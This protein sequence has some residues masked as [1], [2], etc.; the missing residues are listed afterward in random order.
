[1][2]TLEKPYE[3]IS[4]E[5]HDTMVFYNGAR[6]HVRDL[7]LPKSV[8]RMLTNAL[9]P[10]IQ[11]RPTM[12]IVRNTLMEH[13]AKVVQLGTMT[14]TS[15]SYVTSCAFETFSDYH[16]AYKKITKKVK[17][18]NSSIKKKKKKSWNGLALLKT[19][20]KKSIGGENEERKSKKLFSSFRRRSRNKGTQ[21]KMQ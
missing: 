16:P 7:G 19:S 9:S 12:E 10:R 11:D 1:M 6:P 14:P 5:N 8:E 17:R 13:R 21:I 4:D 18:N 2:L 3:D 15:T 20:K